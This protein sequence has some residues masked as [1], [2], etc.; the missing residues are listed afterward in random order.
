LNGNPI[1]QNINISDL[2]IIKLENI[3]PINLELNSKIHQKLAELNSTR[4]SNQKP[5]FFAEDC[6]FVSFNSET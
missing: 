3:N 2:D 4:V 6:V 1:E 5:P